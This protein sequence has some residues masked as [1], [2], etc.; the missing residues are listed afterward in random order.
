MIGFKR[1][2][3]SGLVVSVIGHLGGL[4]VALLSVNPN[5]FH[6]PL[7]DA[8]VVE[9]VTPD[10]LP[11]FEG[12]LSKLYSSGSETPSPADGKGPVTQAPPPKPRAQTEQETQQRPI[13]PHQAQEATAPRPPPPEATQAEL[14]RTGKKEPEK[15]NKSSE[16][17]LA[18]SPPTEQSPEQPNIAEEV[19][20]YVA[21]GGPLGGGFAAPPVDTNV[22]ATTGPRRSGNVSA[23]VRS[24]TG[25]NP[26][27]SSTSRYAFPSTATAR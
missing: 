24:W 22:L 15:Q 21:L 3:R 9:V 18:A 5:A 12:T 14:V 19:R 26:A 7:P 2:I 10:E 6:V 16:R 25:S 20:Q 17:Q 4:I 8:M 1:Y 27:T 11:R 23:C 13:P